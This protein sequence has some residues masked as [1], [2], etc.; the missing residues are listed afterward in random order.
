M[1]SIN[2]MF[3]TVLLILFTVFSTADAL[4]ENPKTIAGFGSSVCDGAGDQ[5]DQG[6]YIGRL[7][8][9]MAERGWNVID[10]SRGGD[11]TI[12]IQDRWEKMNKQPKRPVSQGR[13]LLPH[14]PGYVIIGLSLANEGIR[15]GDEENRE[16]IF[17]QFRTGILGIIERCRKEGMRVV[18]ANCYPHG[19][20]TTEQYDCIKRMNL[21]I[22]SWDV[23]SINLLGAVDDGRGR[24]VD[25]FWRDVGH[26]NAGGHQEMFHAIVPSLFDAM[27]AGKPLPVFDRSPG[28]TRMNRSQAMAFTFSPDDTVH[29]FTTS[30]SVRSSQDAMIAE[31]SGLQGKLQTSEFE[32]NHKT[33]KGH[34]IVKG[35]DLY[36]SELMIQ[37]GKLRYI[38]PVGATLTSTTKI[39]DGKWHRVTLSHRCAQG[40]TLLFL[41]ETML[42]IVKKVWLIPLNFGLS[43]TGTAEF[44]DWLVYRSALN[45]DEVKA[46]CEGRMI[47]SSLEVYAPLRNQSFSHGKAVEN[48]AQSLSQVFCVS[49]P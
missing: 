31:V 22:N 28:G 7:E 6:G 37:N 3:F 19:E 27:E 23:P 47:Q 20:Y 15:Q 45:A 17:E 21:V 25:G 29:S 41:D 4:A 1:R 18:V 44:K 38:S 36:M 16:K 33:F 13:Y 26:P 12:T 5:L 34:S 30:F 14:K 49:I 39:T 35:P 9:L 8:A 48:R 43:L 40:D 42:G 2:R 11:N 32:H 24:W 10:V 46:L